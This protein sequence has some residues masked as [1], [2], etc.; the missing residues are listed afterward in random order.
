MKPK[1]LYYSDCPFFAGCE[2]M[3]A[4]FLNDQTIQKDFSVAFAYNQSEKYEQ[5]LNSRVSNTDYLKFPLSLLKQISY[6]KPANSILV[7]TITHKAFFAFYIPFYKYVSI[8]LN[9]IKLFS[10]FKRNKAD[11]LHINNGGYPAANSCY[12]AVIASKMA[13]IN[14]IIYVVNNIAEDYQHPFRWLDYP[15]DFFIKKWVAVFITGSEFAGNKLKEVLK[16]DEKKHLTINNG[17]QE[18]AITLTKKVFKEKYSIPGNKIIASVVANLEKRKGHIFLL[19]AILQI[20]KQYPQNLNSFFIFEGTGPE[21]TVLEKYIAENEL[22]EQVLQ[23][24][25]IPDIF[26]LLNASDFVILPSIANED[27]PNVIIEAM[28]LGKPVIGTDIAGIPEQ[29]ENNKTGIVVK[30]KNPEEL[31]QA[32]VRL[33]SDSLLLQQFSLEAKKKFDSL[34]EKSI[35]VKKYHNLY[36]SIL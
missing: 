6:R 8:L 2:N 21:K 31:K 29:I 7:W 25:Y 32:I 14:K 5:G 13:G 10:F 22:A 9:T 12:S 15:F 4:N 11:I 27:F 33:A 20:K 23:V 18:R 28:S 16:L 1:I 24:D 36:K 35:S 17:I 34:Y 26:N 3:I 19:E 30:P